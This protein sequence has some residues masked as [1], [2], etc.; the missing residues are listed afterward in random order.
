MDKGLMT[1]LLG[2]V[3]LVIVLFFL[4]NEG[5]FRLRNHYIKHSILFVFGYVIVFF[6]YPLDFVLG[7][8]SVDNLFIWVNREIVVKSLFLS[9]IGL[10]SFL[11]G[12]ALYH[13]NLKTV[14]RRLRIQDTPITTKPLTWIAAVSLAIFFYTVNPLYLIGFYG[15]VQMGATAMYTILLFQVVVFAILIQ[16]TRNMRQSNIRPS[17]FFEYIRL[18]GYFIFVL[19]VIYLL[20]V[21]FSGDRGPIITFSIT[22][23]AG[24][25][26]VSFKKLSLARLGILLIVAAFIIAFLGIARSFDKNLSFVDRM[27]ES[28]RQRKLENPS[29]IPQTS[30][31]ASSVRTLHTVVD[32]VP[33]SHQHTWGRFML[34][35]LVSI[36][37]FSS[38]LL[39]FLPESGHLRFNSPASFVTWIIYGDSSSS[40][41]GTS[42]IADLYLEFALVGVILGMFLFGLFIRFA[43][44]NFY[45]NDLPLLF[46]H[47]LSFVYLGDIIYISRSSFLFGFRMVVW[48]YV[49]L[50]VNKFFLIRR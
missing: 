18:Q 46:P 14:A 47:I 50:L 15:S 30:E 32:Y 41:V 16:N 26:F 39:S 8:V 23:V 13:T 19:I 3:L 48:I 37:P 28:V 4:R 22:Y 38:G 43:E 31:L 27:N 5:F 42:C 24:Y 25:Y 36:I 7:N 10:I 2:L 6:Q 33:S 44:I 29:I 40:G 45:R 9:T 20:S 11:W 21:V 12:Y 35:Q 1:V 34:Q 49:V 17:T